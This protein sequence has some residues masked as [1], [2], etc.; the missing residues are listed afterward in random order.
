MT[1]ET[2]A[3]RDRLVEDF[4]RVIND[5]EDLLKATASQ[6]GDKI[7]SVRT[8]TEDSLR[9]ARRKLSELEGEIVDRTKA[10]VRATDD[11]VHDR[12]WQTAAIAAGVSFL[13]GMLIS[14]RR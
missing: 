7:T 3:A 5:A 9:D 14:G 6:T 4:K 13:L 11:F 1:T 2:Q 10:A 12:P 8:R